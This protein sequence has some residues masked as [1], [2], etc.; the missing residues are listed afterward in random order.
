MR[1]VLEP[2]AYRLREEGAKYRAWLEARRP[3]DEKAERVLAW[4]R[5]EFAPALYAATLGKVKRKHIGLAVSAP[6]AFQKATEQ[7]VE[8]E[9]KAKARDGKLNEYFGTVGERV[10]LE[11]ILMR[12]SAVDG[13]FGTTHIL[14]FEDAQG[15]AFTWF[16]SRAL[17]AEPGDTVKGKATI[18]VHK[19]YTPKH[20]GEAI[21]QTMI[22]RAKFEVLKKE[23]A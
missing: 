15:R 17:D 2:D 13:E 18:K 16:A 6:R 19:D 5:A 1:E 11:I 23:A 20:G 7:A 4:V 22:T 9:Q 21:Q 12:A 3:I 14:S 10:D 8:R